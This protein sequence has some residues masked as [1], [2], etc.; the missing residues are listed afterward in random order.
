MIEDQRKHEKKKVK[1]LN[2]MEKAQEPEKIKHFKQAAKITTRPKIIE[3]KARQIKT[4]TI[5]H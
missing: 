1:M 2:E 4:S 5:Q 3:E